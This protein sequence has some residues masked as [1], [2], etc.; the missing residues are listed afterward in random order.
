MNGPELPVRP[1]TPVVGA[2][3]W[4]NVAVFV[5]WWSGLSPSSMDEHFVAFPRTR[6]LFFFSIPVPALVAALAFIAID[7]W[8]LMA[9]MGGGTLPI[10][11]GA[12]LGGGL[13]GIVWFL[14]RGKDLRRRAER[15]PGLATGG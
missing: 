2:L 1:S 3:L 7:V 12:Q 4:I 5:L 6:V 10:G 15:V 11:H 9:Q 8:G 13:V 14:V